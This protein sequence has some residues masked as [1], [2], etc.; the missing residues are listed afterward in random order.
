MQVLVDMM[1]VNTSVHTIHVDSHFSEHEIYRESVIPYLETNRF[2]PR[3]LAIQKTRPIVYRAKVPGRALLAS[4]TDANIFW[5]LLSGNAE[6][7]FPSRTTTIAVP[8][9]ANLSTPAITAAASSINVAA[10]V[11]SAMSAVRSP[12]T[13]SLLPAAAAI[14]TRAVIPSNA[15]ASDAFAA[16]AAAAAAAAAAPST[17]QKRK[18][19]P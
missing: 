7:A 14:S 10:I 1:K 15:S 6:V 9:A 13:G 2:R 4:R 12:A 8:V 18:A 17:G 19:C 5:M 11:A 3:L 16:T